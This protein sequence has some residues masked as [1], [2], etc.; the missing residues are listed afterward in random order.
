[1]TLRPHISGIRTT[2]AV[3][4]AGT[5]VATMTICSGLT[6]SAPAMTFAT[7]IPHITTTSIPTNSLSSETP[8]TIASPET[9]ATI[10]PVLS[11]NRLGARGA[12]TFTIRYA[13]GAFGVPTPVRRSILQFPAG[14]SLD[15]PSLRSCS[16]A[17]LRARGSSGCPAQSEIGS[18][19]AL[20]EAHAGSLTITEDVALQIFLGPPHN[21]EPTFEILGQG[22]TPIDERMVFSGEV[23]PD[24]APYGEELEMSIPPIPTIALE[25]DASI[26][27][28]SLTIGASNRRRE[29]D[30]NTVLSPSSCPA[31]GFPFAAEFTYSDGSV[32]N[33]LATAKCPR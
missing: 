5:A 2:I 8:A 20:M 25:P 28:F 30:A 3:A 14:L 10:T 27:T 26:V 15:I 4:G 22:Y 13:G 32:G 9:S 31:G 7:T 24:H 21:L 1:M 18:G 29:P 16:V 19:H 6:V 11:P 23:L 12:L 33:A 17:H